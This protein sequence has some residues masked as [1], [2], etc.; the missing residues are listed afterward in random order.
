MKMI[1]RKC[2]RKTH[3]EKTYEKYWMYH[4]RDNTNCSVLAEI[5]IKKTEAVRQI[6]ILQKKEGKKHK[7]NMNH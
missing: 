4:S 7:L 1:G 5:N 2:V 6:A 3:T